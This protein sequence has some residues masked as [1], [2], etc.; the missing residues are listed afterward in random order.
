MTDNFR[1]LST[2]EF[3]NRVGVGQETVR[4]WIKTGDLIPFGRTP[5]NHYRF[6]Q[7]QIWETVQR[8]ASN[9]R[10]SDIATHI[11]ASREKIRRLRKRA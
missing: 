4:R 10:A 1:L 2:R 3:A 8:V 6:H 7:D 5:K 11:Q 9:P